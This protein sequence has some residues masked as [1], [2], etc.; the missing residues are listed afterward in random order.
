MLHLIIDANNCLGRHLIPNLLGYGEH[1]IIWDS[2][3]TQQAQESLRILP[4]IRGIYTAPIIPC[5]ATGA[6]WREHGEDLPPFA[7]ADVLWYLAAST[8]SIPQ[9]EGPSEASDPAIQGTSQFALTALQTVWQIVEIALNNNIPRIIFFSSDAV[10]GSAT[11]ATEEDRLRPMSVYGAVAAGS[12]MILHAAASYGLDVTILR[13]GNVIGLP[14]RYKGETELL[15]PGIL[16]SIIEQI[17]QHPDHITI[18]NDGTPLKN[19]IH[20]T[21]VAEAVMYARHGARFNNPEIYNVGR[22]DTVNIREV[23]GLFQDITGLTPYVQYGSQ[24]YDWP[25][26]PYEIGLDNAKLLSLG[27][28]PRFKSSTGAV[29][30]AIQEWWRIEGRDLMQRASNT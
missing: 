29:R 13:L 21:E 4:G 24:P 9:P 15:A 11:C 6:T 5:A 1:I 20:V 25:G 10:Y 30:Y 27:W 23:V 26:E 7:G 3:I 18:R 22:P 8:S 17:R 12:E 16:G 19:Y 14:L 2:R 28:K